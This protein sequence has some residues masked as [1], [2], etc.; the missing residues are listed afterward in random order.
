M[1]FVR[2]RRPSH[3]DG[4]MSKSED[5]YSIIITETNDYQ[6]RV[7]LDKNKASEILS[8]H[9][10][11]IDYTNFKNSVKELDLINMYDRVWRIGVNE[12]DYRSYDAFWNDMSKPK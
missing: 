4:F 6:F 2:A 11:S 12:L 1:V 3:I 8:K 9:L 5:L 7:H 10:L